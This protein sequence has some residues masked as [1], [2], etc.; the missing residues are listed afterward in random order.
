GRFLGRPP[1][2]M[3]HRGGATYVPNLGHENTLR[4]FGTA[5]AM[6]Y[7]YIET[8]L[9]ASRDGEVFCF[10][11]PDLTRMAGRPESFA[12]LTSAQVRQVRLVGGEPI[13]SLAE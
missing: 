9:R 11:D 10:H 6:G 2:A 8:D 12:D 13:P 3:A 7:E 1:I 5:V 4:A